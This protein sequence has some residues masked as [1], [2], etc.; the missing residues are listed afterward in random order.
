MSAPV[1]NDLNLNEGEW[2]ILT[3]TNHLKNMIGNNLKTF[4]KPI[5]KNKTNEVNPKVTPRI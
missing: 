3:R 4:I 5:D 1:I 2:L